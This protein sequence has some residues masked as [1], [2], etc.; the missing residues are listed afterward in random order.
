MDKKTITLKEWADF[1]SD[2]HN[3]GDWIVC[4]MKN[5]SYNKDNTILECTISTEYAVK[6]FGNWEM[7][8]FM[9]GTY[10]GTEYKGLR[11]LLW[12]PKE[13]EVK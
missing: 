4:L 8:K 11:I 6:L 13:T 1:N 7:K 12:E 9:T 10:P 3:Y 5:G 2:I